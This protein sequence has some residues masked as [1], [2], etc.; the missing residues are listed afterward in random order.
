MPRRP[1]ALRNTSSDHILVHAKLRFGSSGSSPESALSPGEESGPG[2]TTPTDLESAAAAFPMRGSPPKSSPEQPA[3]AAAATKGPSPVKFGDG[4]VK[5]PPSAL[6]RRPSLAPLT[7]ASPMIE[8]TRQRSQSTSSTG[9]A[10]GGPPGG[11]LLTRRRSSRAASRPEILAPLITDLSLNDLPKLDDTVRPEVIGLSSHA[12]TP[13]SETVSPV[14]MDAKT[15]MTRPSLIECSFR[16]T[17][18]RVSTPFPK[19]RKEW[20]GDDAESSGDEAAVGATA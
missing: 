4:L 20:L 10:G 5:S 3:K 11:A 17:E 9:S 2:A 1:S 18:E 7:S 8:G 13:S 6:Q 16:S 12:E 19:S 14:D 15:A